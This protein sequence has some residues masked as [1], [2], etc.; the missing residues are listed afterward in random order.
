M[1]LDPVGELQICG[2]LGAEKGGRKNAVKPMGSMWETLFF[3]VV[4]K[5]IFRTKQVLAGSFNHSVI[6]NT[7]K[8]K[9]SFVFMF[10][11]E[12]SYRACAGKVYPN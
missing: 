9:K 10:D 3:L 11:Y 6:Q 5:D 4:G 2:I 12:P 8:S 7:G 1:Q